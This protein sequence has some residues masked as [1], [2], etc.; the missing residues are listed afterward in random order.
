MDPV[1]ASAVGGS[2]PR[3]RRPSRAAGAAACLATAALALSCAVALDPQRPPA[4]LDA[5]RLFAGESRLQRPAPG[6]IGYDLNTPLFSDHADKLRFVKLPAGA[7]ARYRADAPFDFP[8]GTLIAK[9]FAYPEPDTGGGAEGLRLVETR[10]LWHTADGWIGLP[11]VWNQAQDEARLELAGAAVPVRFTDPEGVER[12]LDYRV[13]NVN[14]CK[15]CH[16]VDGERVS[17]IGPRAAQLNRDRDYDVSGEGGGV[18]NQLARWAR[19]GLLAGAPPP[20]EAPRYPVWDDPASGSLDHR[21]R[22]WL[23]VNCAHCHN[24]AGPART[25]SLDLTF[26]NTDPTLLGVYKSPVAAG[27]GSGENLHDIEPGDPDRSILVYRLESDDPGIMMPELGRALIDRAGIALIREWIAAMPDP[28]AAP[29]ARVVSAGVLR[30]SPDVSDHAEE[31]AA[32]S[33]DQ[34]R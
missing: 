31:G 30:R 4:E 33:R 25:T 18:E 7:P 3:S 21:A 14:Q 32:E 1:S 9:T 2:R 24:P 6:V 19:L 27:R 26:A 10:I 29:A 11:Y 28:F 12:T 20:A 8:V 34:R 15:A 16:R 5:Y 23:E 22:A 17:P 13:P